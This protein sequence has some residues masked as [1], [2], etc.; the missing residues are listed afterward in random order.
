MWT[1]EVDDAAT[2]E[3]R[4]FPDDLKAYVARV[5]TLITED[6][7]QDLPPSMSRQIDGKL[8]ELRLKAGSGIA[9]ALY[10]TMSPKRVIVISAFLK[11]SQKLPQHERDKAVNR[12]N[13]KMKLETARKQGKTK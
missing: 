4:S 2:K 10:F 3:I 5:F 11:K 13:A 8:W 7:P 6:G 1:I 9:R 12:M